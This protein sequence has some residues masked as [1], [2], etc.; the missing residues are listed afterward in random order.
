MKVPT[1]ENLSMTGEITLSGRVLPVGGI[2]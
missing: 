2:R 1:R